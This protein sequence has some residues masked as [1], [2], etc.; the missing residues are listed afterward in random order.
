MVPTIDFTNYNI[1]SN[2]G[3]FTEIIDGDSKKYL[4]TF[5]GQ[6]KSDNSYQIFI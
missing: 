2:L 4:H 5:I 3:S 1:Y 6:I